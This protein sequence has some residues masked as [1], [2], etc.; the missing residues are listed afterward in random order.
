VLYHLY[1]L[2]QAAISPAR[3]AAHSTRFFMRNPFNPLSYTNLGRNAAAAAELLERTTRRYKKPSFG[4]KQTVVGGVRAAVTEETVWRR[5]FCNLIRFRKHLPD[6]SAPAEPRLLIAAP[7]SGHFA[8]LLRGTV[9]AMLPYADV[10]ITDWQD[11][12]FVPSRDGSFDL[13]DYIDYMTAMLELFQGDVHVVA[14][15]QPSVPVIS[16]VA[17]MEARESPSVPRSL[18][19]KGGPIDTRVSQT[20]VNK[21]AEE[22]GIDWFR[23]NVIT[24]VPWP[25]PGHGR[26]VYPGFLQLSGFMLM[27]LDRHVK[28][29]KDLFFHLVRGDGDS[30]EKHK[31]FYDEYLAVMDLA[32]EY[33]LQTID[34]VFVKHQLPK[35]EMFHRGQLI[36]LT[37]IRR[38]ALM[39]IEGEKDDITGLGQCEAAIHLCTG[40]PSA[41]KMHYT[42]EG[43][44]HY[45]IFN[46]SRYR[47]E[48][49][50]RVAEFISSHD[51]RGSRLHRFIHRLAGEKDAVPAAPAPLKNPPPGAKAVALLADEAPH[52]PLP[53]KPASKTRK[54][55]SPG[56]PPAS[57]GKASGP[58]QR[59]R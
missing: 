15:C 32:A 53:A 23:R 36:D 48:I 5:P 37:A 51:V 49:V 59:S 29:H 13:D 27:N 31:E 35:G 4:I 22:R 9:E 6:G 28:A 30:I 42:Q 16:A 25:N 2:G 21:L 1:E 41:K 33:Y 38:T 14:V 39:T 19:L 52:L 58:K 3:A 44:G 7:L 34:K 10:Y 40:L 12:R 46:G 57:Q 17:L 18:I 26:L 47:N 11:A 45:G 8:S 56:R 55:R 50:P 24:S 54:S 20:A 43:V